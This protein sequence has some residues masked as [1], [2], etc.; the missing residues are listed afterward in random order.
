MNPNLLDIYRFLRVLFKNY[1][2]NIRESELI[3][4]KL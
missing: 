2:L 4:F 1:I 3:V